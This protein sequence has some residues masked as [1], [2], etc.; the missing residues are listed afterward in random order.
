MADLSSMTDL[1]VLA[2]GDRQNRL[3]PPRN[4]LGLI[5]RGWFERVIEPH[6]PVGYEDETGFRYG[7]QPTPNDSNPPMRVH[8]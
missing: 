5:L 6:A 7:I 8:N 1:N 2:R 4:S 3:W